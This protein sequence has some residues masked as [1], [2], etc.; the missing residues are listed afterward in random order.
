MKIYQK[1]LI[2]VL[3]TLGLLVRLYKID[4]PIADWH[5]FRQA[6]TASVTNSF[7]NKGIDILHPT[8]QD[9]SNIQS[10]KENINGYRMVELP[11]Y[12]AITAATYT[13]THN[14][15]NFS[16]EVTGRL[17]NIIFSLISA[18]LIY[19]IAF[20]VTKEFWPSI[21]SMS[22]FLFLPF[23]IF[24][25]RAILPEPIGVL[26]LLL[27]LYLF[28]KNLYISA[29][30][31][32]IS[33]L[34]KPYIGLLLFPLFAFYTW[35]KYKKTKKEKL[36]FQLFIFALISLLPFILW[37]KWISQFPEGIPVS[38]WLF[39]GGNMRFHPAWFRWL[40]YER[41]GKLILGIYG[42]IP[43]VLGFAYQKLK[44]Q[45]FS[46]GA[47]LG[48]LI[49]FSI[50]AQG[51]IQHDY[52]QVLT[53]PLLS[54]II[55]FGS[56]YLSKFVFKQKIVGISFCLAIFMATILFSGYEI[57]GY[58]QINNPI[59]IDAGKKAKEILPKDSLIVAPYNGDTAFLYQTSFSGW[60]IEIYDLPLIRKDH[61]NNP[62]YLVS[63]NNDKYTNDVA[64][65]HKVIYK[66]DQITILD[67]SY[68]IPKK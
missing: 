23:N 68:D 30:T 63:I 4:N 61:P 34:I 16:P 3:L 60:P 51:N 20:K 35:D 7:I 56:Y 44:S 31:F 50:I 55:G 36:I 15:T 42:V 25:S 48:I 65:N 41:I 13:S 6:D 33:L 64:Q 52:Y 28:P 43:L 49:Y 27:S 12:N 19:L 10:G 22:V 46:I 5:S 17:I 39:N 21:L 47:I 53:I 1:I 24:Y 40:F 66:T 26:F 29:I 38:N 67:F 9:L 32:A 11:I 54:F 8:Y 37:R 45:R 62:I 2:F 58:Y 14:L 57:K 18:V 59:I